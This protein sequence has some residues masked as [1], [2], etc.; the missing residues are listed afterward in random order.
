MVK[1]PISCEVRVDHLKLYAWA[2]VYVL[3]KTIPE[4]NNIGAFY[5]YEVDL[6]K[7]S[8]DLERNRE[9]LEKEGYDVDKIIGELPRYDKRVE[10]SASESKKPVDFVLITFYY[11][12]ILPL[13]RLI[14]LSGEVLV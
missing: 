5:S 13:K 3:I 8:E 2:E 6:D 7:F 11:L 1:M 4:R 10:L 14:V 9:V 12:T